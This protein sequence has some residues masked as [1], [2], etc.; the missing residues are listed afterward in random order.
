[1]G[2]DLQRL[3]GKIL[4]EQGFAQALAENPEKALKNAEIEPTVDLL[5]AL[6]GVDPEA[7]KNLASSFGQQQ[8][9]V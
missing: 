6:A 8:A 1:M 4:T 3:I 7:L 5:D 2:A 9:A